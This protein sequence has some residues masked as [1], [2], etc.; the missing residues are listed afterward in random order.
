VGER[1]MKR[2][3]IV[4]LVVDKNT[5]EKLK[6]LCSLSSKLWNEV[7]Y[8][9]R[10]MFFEKRGVDLKATYK[11]FYEKYRMLI[12]SAT[13]QQVLNK[14]DEAWNSFFKLL[15]LKKENKLPSFI[16]KVNPPGYKKKNNK[17]MLWAVLRKDQYR[18]ES[19]KIVFKGL[20]AIGWIEI[21]YKGLIHLKG[22]QSRLEIHYDQDKKKWYAH[23]SF[24][25]AEKAVRREWTS[26]PK[27]PKNTLVAG[28]DIGVN[29]LMAI[30][31]E[32]GLAKLV[33]GRP[34][35]AISHYWRVRIAEYQ[36]TLNRYGLR[37]SRR[38]R[39]MYSKWR[40]RVKAYIDS[41]VRQA[42][43]WLYNTGVSIIKIG[44]PKN[45]AQENGNFNNVHVWTYGYLLRRI[46]EVAEEHGITVVYVSEAYTSSKC[47]IHGERCGSRVKRGLFKCARLNKVF[48]ADL[49]GAYNILI[50]PS[51]AWDR[52][53]GL[54][55][56]PGIE[57][58]R[59]NVI[60]NLPA[61]AG[62]LAIHGGEEVRYRTL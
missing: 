58:P 14:N 21:R 20:G 53:N 50:T 23:I 37:T 32:N 45:I 46:Y 22:E 2:T 44:C 24:E 28:I 59:R 17:R 7:N 4:E 11:E 18:I 26:I 52:G 43:E 1:E 19:D 49:V 5:E 33:N 27:Q 56:R 48:N 29:N 6:L 54:E 39:S 25:V 47:P 31:V 15:K 34:L 51:P 12:G 13:A 9:R 3:S 60:P 8:A 35:K 38:L 16:T 62:T 40:R 10:W 42:I 55:T 36:S 41:R 61:L 57:P 30:Y